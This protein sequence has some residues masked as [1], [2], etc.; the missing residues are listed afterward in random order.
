MTNRE[1][2]DG[3]GSP[4][5][6]MEIPAWVGDVS[7]SEGTLHVQIGEVIDQAIDSRHLQPGDRLPPEREL[8]AW[9]GVNRL[10]LRQALSDLER[11]R[12]IKRSV[13]RRGGTF[14]AEPTVER[15]LSSFA[16]FPSRPAGSASPRVRCCCTLRSFPQLARWPSPSSSSRNRR[17]SRSPGCASQTDDRLYSSRPAFRPSGSL[18]CWASRST[19]RF[20]SFLQCVTTPDLVGPSRLWSQSAPAVM[21]HSCSG[22]VGERRCCSSSGLPLTEAADQSSSPATCS[23][24]TAHG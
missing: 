19:A 9:F 16:G 15:D 1:D 24:V 5:R 11:R 21:R 10:T 23:G 17:S 18:G 22:S 6:E 14:V 8:A 13:G 2:G 12:R 20:T 7:R 4:S 3:G